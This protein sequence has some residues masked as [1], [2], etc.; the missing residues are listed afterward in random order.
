MG[1]QTAQYTPPPSFLKKYTFLKFHIF[2]NQE[3]SRKSSRKGPYTLL[4]SLEGPST[5]LVDMQ[6]AQ[7]TL[8]SAFFV[9]AVRHAF[10]SV[11]IL[12]EWEISRKS[13]GKAYFTAVLGVRIQP[14]TLWLISILFRTP[15]QAHSE[16]GGTHLLQKMSAS[17][18]HLVQGTVTHARNPAPTPPHTYS[19]NTATAGTSVSNEQ[20]TLFEKTA[21]AKRI[22][23]TCYSS[24]FYKRTPRHIG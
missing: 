14:R 16:S 12:L 13:S 17:A 3:K 22:V 9:T 23:D 18:L 2:Q 11:H 21:T 24:L 5:T 7:D 19:V 1:I 8:V 10:V 15:W 6:A 20:L 4:W